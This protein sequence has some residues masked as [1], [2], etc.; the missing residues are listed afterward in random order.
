MTKTEKNTVC[1]YIITYNRVNLLKRALNSVLNQSTKVHEIIIVDDCSTDGTEDFCLYM[2]KK[3][4]AILYIR[5]SI[6]MGA[7]A[8][9]NKAIKLSSS[10]FITGLDDDDYFSNSRINEFIAAWDKKDNDTIALCSNYIIKDKKSFKNKKSKKDRIVNNDLYES[11][12]VGNQIFSLREVFIQVGGFD[13][14]LPAWQD[15]ELWLRV[16]QHG[17]IAVINSWSYYVDISHPHERISTQKIEKIGIAYSSIIKT[18]T[19][20]KNQKILLQRQLD[21]YEN[22]NPWKYLF[23]SIINFSY[24]IFIISAK[25]I[26]KNIIKKSKANT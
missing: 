6:N 7:P 16:T 2:A 12:Y 11:N 20:K 8:S 17:P 21:M 23:L 1:V 14:N 24:L 15:L 19:P 5:N 18:H 13:T 4:P 26:M 25:D 9:R 22:Y 3:H 10:M